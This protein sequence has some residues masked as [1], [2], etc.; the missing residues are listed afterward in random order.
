MAETSENK[1]II[2]KVIHY[3]WFGRNPLPPSAVKCIESWKKYLPDFEIKEWNEES[4]DVNS[5]E[6]S[7]QAYEAKK[8]AFVSDYARFWILYHY[9][10]VYFDV[11]V[12]VI[13]PIDDLLQKGPIWAIET[14]ATKEKRGSLNGG[15]ILATEKGNHIYDKILEQYKTLPF[16]DKQGNISQYTMNPLITD[17]FTEM[18]FKC[19][20]EIECIE[21]NYFYP[22]DYFNPLDPVTGVLKKTENTRS[23]H[24]YMA[25]WLPS[26]PK[27]KKSA[28]QLYHRV[29]G[30]DFTQKIKR[31]IKK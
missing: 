21:G 4:F 30:V 24:W 7:R 12:E 10:G 1:Q 3:C 27:W 20:G 31:L 5:V 29:F 22:K 9:G 26:E 6:Y 28:K 13:K 14:I 18:G 19:S 11:D 2:P 25:S 15:L 16:Y 17:L 8:Y 23:I